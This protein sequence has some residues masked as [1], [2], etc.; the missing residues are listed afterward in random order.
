MGALA[1]RE[2][3]E[4][5]RGFPGPLAGVRVLEATNT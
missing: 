1:G 4:F 2:K 3:S 5:Y